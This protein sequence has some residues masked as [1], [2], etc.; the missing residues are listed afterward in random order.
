M[1][2]SIISPSFNSGQFI[3]E[4]LD[5]IHNQTYTNFEH[6]IIDSC[7][8]DNTSEIIKD[9][10]NVTFVSERDTGQTEALNKGFNLSRG[11]I[12]A[13]QNADDLYLP[14][15][16]KKVVQF[17]QE[18]ANVDIVYGYYK[19]IDEN[20]KWIC[21][22]KPVEWDV[23]KFKHFRF[24]PMQPTVF[25]RRRVYE[26]IGDLN[27]SLN[28]TMDLDMFAKAVNAGFNFKLLPE[29]LGEF[30]VHRN[31]KTQNKN[32]RVDIKRETLQVLRVNFD[33]NI[34]NTLIFYFFYHRSELASV[35]KR[36]FFKN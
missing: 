35:L 3:R 14:G 34:L 4:T 26:T 19:L 11:E 16:F 24:V 9:F 25:W 7:S 27:E 20:G 21:D 22:V 5:S 13:W 8:T 23:W 10:G 32:N 17:F 29:F 31:S 28:Y 36:R 6:I 30:R 2:I 15:T 12:L 1:R 18:N 33:Y